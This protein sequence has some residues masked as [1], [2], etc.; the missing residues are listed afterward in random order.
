MDFTFFTY[1]QPHVFTTSLGTLHIA[2]QD[3][4]GADG[5]DEGFVLSLFFL[6]T[7]INHGLECHLRGESL[8]NAFY[9]Y[10]GELFFQ[11]YDE[12][13]NVLGRLRRGVVHAFG[14]TNDKA[15]NRLFCHL[16]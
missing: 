1:S 8:V 15:F 10:G 12:G 6:E 11:F 16:V 14:F 13:F 7:P 5:V 3:N 9:G 2:L 4:H